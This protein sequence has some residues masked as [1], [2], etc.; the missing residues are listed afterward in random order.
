MSHSYKT[1]CPDPKCAQPLLVHAGHV[2]RS[3]NCPEC[4]REFRVESFQAAEPSSDVTMDFADTHDHFDESEEAVKPEMTLTSLGRF[5]LRAVL[6][7]GGFGRV[8]L[9]YDPHLDQMVALKVSL[10]DS[11]KKKHRDRILKEARAASLLR[12][13]DAIVPAYEC[14]EDKGFLYIVFEY[15]EGMSLASR[16]RQGSVDRRQAVEWIR[17]I[18]G[19][20][21]FAHQNNLIHRD[22]KPHNI[23]IN[24]Q[25]RPFITD[26]GL[27]RLMSNTDDLTRPGNFTGT[28]PYMAPELLDGNASDGDT[29]GEPFAEQANYDRAVDQ[30][31]LGVVL[32]ECLTGHRPFEGYASAVVGMKLSQQPPPPSRHDPT[33]PKDLDA[34]CLKAIQ[35]HPKHRYPDCAAFAEALKG[36]LD[37]Q[38]KE[39]APDDEPL[40]VRQVPAVTRTRKNWTAIWQVFTVSVLLL[41][42]AA[43]VYVWAWQLEPVRVHGTGEPDVLPDLL[44]TASDV[45]AWQERCANSLHVDANIPNSIGMQFSL[46][47]PAKFR[48]GTSPEELNTVSA[49]RAPERYLEQIE[50]L[51]EQHTVEIPRPFY[52]S[53]F[54]VTQDQFLMVMGT[55]PSKHVQ[56]SNPV[57]NLTWKEADQFCVRLSNLDEEKTVG[58]RYRLPEEKE[59]EFACGAGLR[60][61]QSFNPL[62]SET[63]RV[64]TGNA[65][66]LGLHDMLDNVTEWCSD[67]FDAHEYTQNNR[68]MSDPK[69]PSAAI[70]RAVRGGSANSPVWF[71][72]PGHRGHADPE[73]GDAFRGFRVLLEIHPAK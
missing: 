47:P 40:P 28:I 58:R 31:S 33:I 16:L 26:F 44:K 60:K 48:M 14:A 22:V 37:E 55:N 34:I 61:K 68:M 21:H 27:V 30:Y 51:E 69:R 46:I 29:D 24:S 64:G 72:R 1:R 52:L 19:A 36:W 63:R 67:G 41:T 6:G 71:R 57:E 39:S 11:A 73:T 13:H 25:A 45:L 42:V 10:L 53:Q 8:Y 5:E 32:F 59:W 38:S 70:E 17:V 54:E 56:G 9:A 23:L 20:L 35:K 18:A 66:E 43:I 62:V 15:I 7:E 12:R 49:L 65:N 4:G 50:Q 2:G 3:V